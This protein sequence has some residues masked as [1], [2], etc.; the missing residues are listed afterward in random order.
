MKLKSIVAITAALLGINTLTSCEDSTS[1]IGG[2]LVKDEVSIT[3]DTLEMKIEASTIYEANFDSRA[4]T[5]LLGRINVPEYGSLDCS[6]VSQLLTATKMN[7][8]D[9]IKVT[10]VDS[11]RMILKVPRGSLTGDSLAPQQLKV[12]ALTRQ[13]PSDISS[14]FDPTGFYNP[15]NPLGIKS[16]TLSALSMNDSMFKKGADISI[17][18]V[19]PVK[20]AQELFTAYREK[21]EIFQWPQTFA[22]YFPGVYVEQNFGNGCVGVI[23]GLEFYLYWHYNKQ[24]YEKKDD[25]S[26]EY[27][28]VDQLARDSVCLLSSRPEVLSA[29]RVIYK[30]SDYLKNLANSGKSIITT[31][32]GYYINMTFPAKQLLEKYDYDL[33]SSAVVSKLTFEIP[34][35]AVKN[36]YGLPAAPYLLLVKKSEREAFFRENKVPDDKT[37]FIAEYDEDRESYTFSGMREYIL[38]I[39]KAGNATAEETEFSL[40]PVIVTK[41][42]VEGYSSPTTYV[43]G[44]APY[45]GRP[46]V[47]ELDTD[48]SIICFTYSRQIIQ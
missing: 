16:Y 11:L 28:Y 25:D 29:N 1:P 35:K 19:M 30:V 37:S 43:T 10:D 8:P 20:M 45:I 6:F 14:D 5:K 40:V 7:I 48:H 46:T 24:V 42:V 36:D 2:S 12:Y 34:A 31:P 27:H 9:S 18:V 39:I 17:P 15:Q 3:L 32:G 23:S 41:E 47:T 22:Q 21:P 4:Q 13:L 38:D 33:R 44:C 26:G